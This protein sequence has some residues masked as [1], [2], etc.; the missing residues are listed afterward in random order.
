M[1]THKLGLPNLTPKQKAK[2]RSPAVDIDQ[3]LNQVYPAFHSPTDDSFI[4]GLRIVDRFSSQISFFA[5]TNT[6]TEQKKKHLNDLKNTFSSSQISSSSICIIAD[7][8]VKK[9]TTSA[10]AHIWNLNKVVKRVALHATKVT[11]NEAEIMAI[12]LGLNYAFSC[13][14]TKHITVI[15]D[16]IHGARKIIDMTNHSY[17]LITAPISKD[18]HKF[19]SKSPEHSISFWHC[20][21]NSNWKPHSDVDKD[22]KASHLPPILP[23]RVT[24]NYSKKEECNDLSSQWRM[25]FQATDKKGL[26]F[27]DLRD[28]KNNIIEPYYK[29]R[30][31]WLSQFGFS[32]SMYTRMTRLITNHAPIGDYRRHF[33][34]NENPLCP[35]GS[36]QVETRYHI[37]RECSRFNEAWRPPDSLLSSVMI[38]LNFN[39]SA[40]CFEDN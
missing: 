37:L 30:G 27:L 34:P 12:R 20:P 11:S 32:N 31:P 10:I 23:N 16:S 14:H 22:I 26:N 7:G 35:C 36:G 18:T 6:N 5:S 15:T 9:D 8:G 29:N 17:S 4:P 33:F 21:S 24:W 1:A 19:L 13:E 28:G 3:R 2:L 39:R 40:F 38:F 25:F